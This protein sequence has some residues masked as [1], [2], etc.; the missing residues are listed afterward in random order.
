MASIRTRSASSEGGPF[1]SVIV[2]LSPV[3]PR[4]G[5]ARAAE[6]PFFVWA[7][8]SS[9]CLLAASSSPSRL[10]QLPR[11]SAP[12]L[13]PGAL[14]VLAVFYNKRGKDV[15]LVCVQT[16]SQPSPLYDPCR[17]SFHGTVLPILHPQG[18]R[19]NVSEKARSALSSEVLKK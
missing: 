15:Q 5:A 18:W 10:R 16:P 8:W 11:N 14:H 19:N 4:A 3:P 17:F 13:V 9:L 2:P 12:G 6:V 7:A 1:V